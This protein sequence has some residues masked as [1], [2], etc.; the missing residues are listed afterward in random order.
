MRGEQEFFG[1]EAP[2]V[3]ATK[4]LGPELQPCWGRKK[5]LAQEQGPSTPNW[6]ILDA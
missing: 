5:F 4:R 3:E 1:I 2:F 6:D